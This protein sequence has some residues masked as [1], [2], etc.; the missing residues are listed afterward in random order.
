M[1]LYRLIE[2]AHGD[3]GPQKLVRYKSFLPSFDRC[4]CRDW[5]QWGL[6]WPTMLVDRASGRM[7]ATPIWNWEWLSSLFD[8][9]R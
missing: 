4:N 5:R 9:R 6:A 7:T 1:M 3:F 2:W 8:Q